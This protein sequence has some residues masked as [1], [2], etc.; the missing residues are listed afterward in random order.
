MPFSCPC[1]SG[2]I[3]CRL[4]GMSHWAG[5]CFE[6]SPREQSSPHSLHSRLQVVRICDALS[7][8]P[9][10]CQGSHQI[11]KHSHAG[12]KRGKGPQPPL[13]ALCRLCM[14]AVPNLP[15]VH[16]AKSSPK[17]LRKI[18]KHFQEKGGRGGRKARGRCAYFSGFPGAGG[19]RSPQAPGRE[20]AAI[21]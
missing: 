2:G 3:E 10:H 16:T 9:H 14:L 17:D 7:C 15:H 21:T 19:L 13:P 5:V 18:R 8:M 6:A 4:S 1:W 12:A 11:H 20:A